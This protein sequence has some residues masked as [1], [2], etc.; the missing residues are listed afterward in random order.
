MD[1]AAED[2]GEKLGAEAE[3]ENGAAVFEGVDEVLFFSAEPGMAAVFEDAPGA[4][5]DDEA[6]HLGEVVGRGGGVP[7]GGAE[8]VA[9][10]AGP[11]GDF[12]GALEGDVLEDLEAHEES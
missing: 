11:A 6:V 3:A 4:A 7:G 5:E 10:V 8:G 2:V 9:A 1:A 12:G